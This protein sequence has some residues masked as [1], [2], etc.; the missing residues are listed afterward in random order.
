MKGLGNTCAN[1]DSD[2]INFMA[3]GRGLICLALTS[4]RISQLGL[5]LMSTHSSNMK[6]HLQFLL[7]H[8]GVTTGI[9]ARPGLTVCTAIV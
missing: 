5:S 8:E 4:D 3:H 2:A 9:S 1:G 7:R 6:L